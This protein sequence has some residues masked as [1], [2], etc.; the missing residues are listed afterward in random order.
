MRNLD[1]LARDLKDFSQAF[2]D[3]P[4]IAPLLADIERRQSKIEKR[5]ARNRLKSSLTRIE[6][7][8]MVLADEDLPLEFD[9]AAYCR[10]YRRVFGEYLSVTSWKGHKDTMVDKGLIEVVREGQGN[11]AAIYREKR[12][13]SSS[14]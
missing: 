12:S 9:R 5:V 11:K 2:P 3:C 1:L 10:A 14:G 13:K 7:V 6:I 8:Q 4:D